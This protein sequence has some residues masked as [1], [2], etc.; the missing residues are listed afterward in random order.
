MKF[1][2]HVKNNRSDWWE[3]YDEEHV[4]DKASA[5]EFGRSVV[6]YWNETL[7]SQELPR[8]F[9]ESGKYERTI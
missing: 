8:T 1:E 6:A 7:H 2:I 5:D 3:C 9:L 4:I